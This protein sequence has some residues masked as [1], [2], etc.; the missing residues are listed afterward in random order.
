MAEISL[1]IAGCADIVRR[2]IFQPLSYVGGVRVCGIA[3]RTRS[4][5]EAMAAEFGVPRVYDSLEELIGCPQ[6][7]AV[8][9]ALSNELHAEWALKAARAGKHVLVE[10]P[11]AL[12]GRECAML[13]RELAG[14][15]VIV[16]EG[17]MVRHHPWQRELTRIV[18]EQTYG[19]LLRMNTEMFIPF[20]SPPEG[21]YRCFPE[22]GGGVWNDLGCY[23]LQ[24]V[25]LLPGLDRSRVRDI[26][27]ASEFAGP[28][29]C[30]WTFEAALAYADGTSASFAASFERPY[31][32]RHVLETEHAVLTIN[33]FFRANVGRYKITIKVEDHD[34]RPLD[35]IV[36]EPMHYYENQLKYFRDALLEPEPGPAPHMLLRESFE[37]VRWLEEIRECACRI[38][39]I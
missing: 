31:R 1:G 9:I 4:R 12:N 17:M 6:P 15:G 21:N 10:K 33:D 28:R 14:S 22:K 35:S 18:H 36:F 34:G 7:A 37:R 2:A 20:K 13:E 30:D 3:N 32:T 5:A 23:W 11:L 24:L 16:L 19:R 25:Q 27:G 8:Y 38:H 39:S 29:G 26:R